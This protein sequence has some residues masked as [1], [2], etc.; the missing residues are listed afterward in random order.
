MKNKIMY[1]MILGVILMGLVGC[2]GGTNTTAQASLGQ[3]FTLPYGKSVNISGENLSIKFV[4]VVTDSRCP[5]GVQCVWAGEAKVKLEVTQ[6]NST[7]ETVLTETGGTNGFSS[8]TIN[9]YKVDFRVEPYPQAN[10][11]IAPEDYKLV[12]KITK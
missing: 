7:L 8:G 4:A 3:E 2:S 1:I 11:T 6:N 9:A 5:T 10:K 12:M